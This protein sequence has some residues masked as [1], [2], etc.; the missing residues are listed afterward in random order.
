MEAAGSW[1][2][3][4]IITGL[5]PMRRSSAKRDWMSGLTM[6]FSS[7]TP[8]ARLPSLT[9]S[10]VLPRRATSSARRKTWSGTVVSCAASQAWIASTAPLR[11]MRSPR[12][13][14]LMRDCAV[15][16]TNSTSAI[17]GAG[18]WM[19]LSAS[20]TML[21]P[22]GEGGGLAVAEGDGAGL[23]Q[24]QHVDVAGHLHR[25]ARLGQHV[26][27]QCTVHAGN[28]NRWQQAADGG[29]DQAHQQRDQ[30]QRIDLD[31]DRSTDRR[32]RRHHYQEGERHRRQQ[33]GQRDL[34]RGLLPVGA[35][36]QRDH[37]VQEAV[38]R[39]GGHP[40]DDLVGQHLGAADH[41]GTVGAGLAQY[42]CRFAVHRH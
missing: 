10:G 23:V 37:P 12:F 2:S 33:Q 42:R 15:K 8:S 18:A 29:R 39:F 1:M 22:S 14:P 20:A 26:G 19:A 9:I 24:Q 21:R 17:W 25:L 16:G 31:A 3:P 36:P 40:H 27:G 7:T 13:T 32:Q 34:V 30:Q 6:S 4:G 11:I 35:L 5:R 41:A 28:T 38:A